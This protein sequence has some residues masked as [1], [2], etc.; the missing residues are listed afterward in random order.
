[1]GA[2]I[3]SQATSKAEAIEEAEYVLELVKGYDIDMPIVLDYE[4]YDGGRLDNAIEE[5]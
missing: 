5:K 3:Y 1:M 2:Y 4:T